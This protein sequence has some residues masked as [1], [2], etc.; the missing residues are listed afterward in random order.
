MCD[1]DY[2]KTCTT[3][4]HSQFHRDRTTKKA[5]WN[6]YRRRQ[7]EREAREDEEAQAHERAIAKQQAR[8]NPSDT[9]AQSNQLTSAQIAM[10]MGH[11]CDIPHQFWNKDED[12]NGSTPARVT[13]YTESGTRTDPQAKWHLDFP[14]GHQSARAQWSTII[15]RGR[16]GNDPK[17]PELPQNPIDLAPPSR[18]NDRNKACTDKPTNSA[19]HQKSKPSSKARRHL[20]L[21]ETEESTEEGKDREET[22]NEGQRTRGE[23]S[24]SDDS[25]DSSDSV[26]EQTEPYHRPETRQTTPKAQQGIQS[27]EAPPPPRAQPQTQPQRPATTNVTTTQQQHNPGKSKYEQEVTAAIAQELQRRGNGT[28]GADKARRRNQRRKHII[29]PRRNRPITVAT[30]NTNKTLAR[31]PVTTILM[32]MRDTDV[33]AIQEHGVRVDKAAWVA[34]IRR[35]LRKYGYEIRFTEHT[36]IVYDETALQGQAEWLQKQ[37]TPDGRFQAMR[38]Q[39]GGGQSTI[40]MAEYSVV[41]GGRM[42]ERDQHHQQLRD[43]LNSMM[44]KYSKDN[45][46]LMGDLQDTITRAETD[47]VNCRPMPMQN[48]GSLKLATEPP[49]NLKSAFRASNDST[50]GYITRVGAKGGRG[51]DHI[52]VSD[53]LRSHV[54]ECHVDWES[55]PTC[56]TDHQRVWARIYIED[57]STEPHKA[58]PKADTPMYTRLTDIPMTRNPQRVNTSPTPAPQKGASE[59]ETEEE[60]QHHT[61]SQYQPM[62]N[63]KLYKLYQRRIQGHRLQQPIHQELVESEDDEGQDAEETHSREEMEPAEKLPLA[64]FD[65]ARYIT[66]DLAE[67]RQLHEALQIEALNA[68]QQINK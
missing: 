58:Q 28:R 61:T 49:H 27:R 59:E 39:T 15:Y 43:R 17:Q 33:L 60:K 18:H 36:A 4:P 45:T 23:K 30:Y 51:I 34:S 37:D 48:K 25:E 35:Q 55:V 56:N 11:T 42:R 57:L 12:P 29:A 20:T 52:L 47:T 7:Q 50:K 68:K 63:R 31:T 38:V 22:D 8:N 21:A 2:C 40:I 41:T 1:K 14:E 16:R 19:K 54:Q 32:L 10:V 24:E 44:A 9:S 66:K 53:N 67:T 64:K 13:G 46:I 62:V 5:A 3:D 65:D 6:E 26:E